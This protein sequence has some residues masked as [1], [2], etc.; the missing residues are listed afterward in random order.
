MEYR[1]PD[2]AIILTFNIENGLL[3]PSDSASRQHEM[4]IALRNI[5]SKTEY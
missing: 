4:C 3:S 2:P 1:N 5:T